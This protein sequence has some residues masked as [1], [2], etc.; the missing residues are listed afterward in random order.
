MHI[1]F[2]SILRHAYKF[3]YTLFVCRIFGTLFPRT[4]LKILGKKVVVSVI[5]DITERKAAEEK[6]RESET[7]NREVVTH[8]RE[9]IIAYD[10]Q[11]RITLW[12]LAM[13]EL[14][15][16][17]AQ[18]VMGKDAIKLF[19]FHEKTGVAGLLRQA[20]TGKSG[21]SEDFEFRIPSTG[22]HGWARGLYSPLYNFRGE[23][24]G[25]IG[26]VQNITER[27]RVEKAL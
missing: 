27:K 4:T 17:P 1:T 10:R 9:G 5:R 26:I 18:E 19:P 8:A 20:L 14:T 21:E 16:I 2:K 15:G 25:V 22:R 13:E 3:F 11:L 12:N 6:I 23:I 24:M 7:F